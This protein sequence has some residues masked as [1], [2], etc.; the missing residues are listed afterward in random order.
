[1]S[2]HQ[3]EIININAVSKLENQLAVVSG[4]AVDLVVGI[5]GEEKRDEL[6]CK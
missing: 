1:L 2:K 4:K 6:D 3:S 5:A